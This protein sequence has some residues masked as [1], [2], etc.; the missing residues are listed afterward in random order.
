MRTVSFDKKEKLTAAAW[1]IQQDFAVILM[2]CY[3]KELIK[4]TSKS[5]E[6]IEFNEKQHQQLLQKY[7]KT[8]INRGKLGNI[9]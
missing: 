4:A 8:L 2:E 5:G 9:T 3:G 1:L 7:D 6:S